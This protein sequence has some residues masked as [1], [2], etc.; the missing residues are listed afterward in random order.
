MK[1]VGLVIK[2]LFDIVVSLFVLILGSPLLI[3]LAILVRLSSPGPVLFMQERPGYRGKPFKMLKFRSMTVNDSGNQALEWSQAEAARITPIGRFMRD[4]GLDE[5]PQLLNILKGDMSIIGPRPPLMGWAEKFND[6]QRVMFQ[7]RPG[8]LSL[9]AVEGRR[10]IPM[11]HRI[12]LHVQY[13]EQWSLWLDL[14]IFWRVAFV[15]LCRRNAT[16]MGA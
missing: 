5:L 3:L 1:H 11:E 8:V 12:E 13:V 16:E 10:T 6:R 14:I 2:R 7:M 15:V 9:A 4:Y